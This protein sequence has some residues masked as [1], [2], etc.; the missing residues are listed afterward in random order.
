MIN[1]NKFSYAVL[2]VGG[3][4]HVSV[5]RS[6]FLVQLKVVKISRVQGGLNSVGHGFSAYTT[7]NNHRWFSSK[8]EEMGNSAHNPMFEEKDKIKFI[9]PT[10]DNCFIDKDTN[11]EYV[12]TFGK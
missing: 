1:K 9:K 5:A 11:I 7:K 10:G 6:L 2:L 12:R 4:I 3:D 8:G